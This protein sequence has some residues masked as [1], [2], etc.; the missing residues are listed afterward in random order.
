[1]EK[2]EKMISYPDSDQ[3]RN[4]N[5]SRW[6]GTRH[7]AVWLITRA[8]NAIFSINLALACSAVPTSVTS[9][10]QDFAF[11]SIDDS[12]SVPP[13]IAHRRHASPSRGVRIRIKQTQ[14]RSRL[15]GLGWEFTQHADGLKYY[16]YTNALWK[17]LLSCYCG[18]QTFSYI[19]YVP[20]Y[21]FAHVNFL[22]NEYDDYDDDYINNWC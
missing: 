2:R 7:D 18:L 14:I 4:L 20:L 10:L 5:Q 13:G 12:L 16:Y 17:L 22:L 15:C 19:F 21:L 1:M 11:W 9:S 6:N 8:T 3:F